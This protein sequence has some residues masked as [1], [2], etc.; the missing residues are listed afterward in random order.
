MLQLAEEAMVAH[1]WPGAGQWATAACHKRLCIISPCIA[2]YQATI[3]KK[4]LLFATAAILL[5]LAAHAQLTPTSPKKTPPA[6]RSSKPA[7]KPVGKAPT[8]AGTSTIKDTAKFN[9]KFQRSSQPSPMPVRTPVR[10]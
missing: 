5:S 2:H 10:E 7:T 6:S 3:M 9:R 1:G 4:Q 8:S